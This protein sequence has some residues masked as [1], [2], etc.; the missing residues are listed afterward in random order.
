MLMAIAADCQLTVYVCVVCSI[1]AR[2]SGAWDRAARCFQALALGVSDKA[3]LQV[4][5][6]GSACY[7]AHLPLHCTT[8]LVSDSICNARKRLTLAASPPCPRSCSPTAEA[9]PARSMPAA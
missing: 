4:G 8:L 5:A 2:R 9:A 7:A 6:A 1:S 3:L